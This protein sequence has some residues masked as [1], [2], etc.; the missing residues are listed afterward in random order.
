MSFLLVKV[1]QNTEHIRIAALTVL[2]HLINSLKEVLEPHVSAIGAQL[3]SLT[4]ADAN[5]LPN[6]VK[7]AMVQVIVALAVQGHL[8]A[9]DTIYSG[10]H[11][12]LISF[13]L[14]LCTS[15]PGSDVGSTTNSGFD[16][17]LH[18]LSRGASFKGSINSSPAN[19]SNDDLR[20]MCE[21]VIHLLVTTQSQ[22]EN[23][24]WP[25]L[26]RFALDPEY[27]RACGVIARAL[28]HLAVKKCPESNVMVTEG[29]LSFILEFD[30]NVSRRARVFLFLKK[31]FSTLGIPSSSAIV[32][33]YLVLARSP[34]SLEKC[35]AILNFLLHFSEIVHP[36]LAQLWQAELPEL[37]TQLKGNVMNQQANQNGWLVSLE[38]LAD[39]TI[40]RMKLVAPEWTNLFATSLMEQIELYG[41]Q[42]LERGFLLNLLGICV[43]HGVITQGPSYAID[44]IMTT[45]RHHVI[46]ESVGCANAMGEI[47][48]YYSVNL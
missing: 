12:Q 44:L 33:R 18:P 4:I 42:P 14:K 2:K 28:A 47:N 17:F 35:S 10:R 38:K 7:K 30:R 8:L 6:N 37:I 25:L 40:A 15:V 26:L 13:L 43:Y 20:T 34:L 5:S 1:D 36:S 3:K 41:Q 48:R 46:E 32:A 23:L 16:A 22:M 21:N 24:F 31:F 45:V 27:N 39:V 19:V 9:S 11:I 29:K